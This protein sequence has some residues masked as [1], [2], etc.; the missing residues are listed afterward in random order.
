MAEL[1]ADQKLLERDFEIATQWYG[2]LA[3][4]SQQLC[5]Q[6]HIH[7]T[8]DHQ[9]IPLENAALQDFDTKIPARPRE[10]VGVWHSHEHRWKKKKMGRQQFEQM[11]TSRT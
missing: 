5:A 8:E 4:V 11:A 9:T 1:L 7:I 10:P 3:C 6:A 2:C